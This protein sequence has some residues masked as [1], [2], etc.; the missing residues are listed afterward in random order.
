MTHAIH[1]LVTQ[2]GTAMQES[3]LCA[4]HYADQGLRE[5]AVHDAYH[6]WDR[7][8]WV[9]CSGNEFLECWHC[10]DTVDPALAALVTAVRAA[11]ASS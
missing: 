9:D 10:G 7:G 4:T 3:A 5:A 6:D 1:A 8:D 2:G 11:E